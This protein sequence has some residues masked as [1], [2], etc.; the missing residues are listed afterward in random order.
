MDVAQQEERYLAKVEVAGSIPVIHS[1]PDRMID[2]TTYSKQTASQVRI[3]RH[4]SLGPFWGRV[5]Y[6][7]GSWRL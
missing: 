5:V 4:P 7:S 6:W 1:E 3:L 2:G